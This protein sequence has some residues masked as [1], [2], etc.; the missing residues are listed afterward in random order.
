MPRADGCRLWV[1][2]RAERDDE[3]IRVVR[4]RVG[5]DA[6]LVGIDRANR[7]LH[8]LHP[9][10][11]EVAVRVPYLFG[12]RPAEHHFQ[13]GEPEDEVVRLV[14][15]DDVDL[16]SEF[17]RQPGGQLQVVEPGTRHHDSRDQRGCGTMRM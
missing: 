12:S 4:P 16:R 15:E 7:R 9:G 6:F 11:D 2:I 17:V 8:E 13:L 5:F 1:Q 14:D 10:L 3:H